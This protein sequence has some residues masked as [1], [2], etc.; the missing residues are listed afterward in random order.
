MATSLKLVFGADGNKEVSL[1]FPY[2]DGSAD[3]E[4]VKSLMAEIVDNG[5]I[6][7]E[8][9]LSAVGAEFVTRTVTPVNLG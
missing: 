5:E 9:P 3:A 7:V 2:A 8:P 1:T 4:D 6:Y